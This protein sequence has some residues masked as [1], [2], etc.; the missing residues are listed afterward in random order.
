MKRTFDQAGSFSKGLIIAA[1][2]KSDLAYFSYVTFSCPFPAALWNLKIISA[3]SLE[4]V[5]HLGY[6]HDIRNYPMKEGKRLCCLMCE[7]SHLA[8]FTRSGVQVGDIWR[9]SLAR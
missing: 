5:G 3:Q 8:C 7:T 6:Y 9:V 1:L 4:E 2:L